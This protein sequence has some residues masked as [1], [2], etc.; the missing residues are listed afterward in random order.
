M[1]TEKPINRWAIFKA[2]LLGAFFGAI[3]ATVYFMIALV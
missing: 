3:L 1:K 2:G